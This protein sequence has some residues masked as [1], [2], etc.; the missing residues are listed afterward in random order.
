MEYRCALCSDLSSLGKS[1]L[2]VM[3][4]ALEML[5]VEACPVATGLLS[6]QSD[7][8]LSPYTEDASEAYLS[9]L[10]TWERLG[11][12][13][14]A[15]YSGWFF[16]PREMERTARFVKTHPSLFYLCDPVLGDGGSLYQTMDDE[17]VE[18]MRGLA[19]CA[20]L[21]TP[22][23]TEAALLLDVPRFE[24]SMVSNL[25]GRRHLVTGL[26]TDTGW[27]VALDD[28][29]VP[30]RHRPASFPGTGDLFDAIL[31]GLLLKG[32]SLREAV[33]RTTTLVYLAIER[34][35]RERKYGISVSS[36]RKELVSL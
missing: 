27:C 14:D 1:S 34:T 9:I 31:L 35:V 13:F 19:S 16:S 18:A 33:E 3:I 20:S 24:E 36:I 22:N 17:R 10:D 30:F 21:V 2:T 15:L 11:V 8:F 25:P 28:G 32:H 7:G 29:K 26:R 12:S 5:G 6:S 4:P 23:P